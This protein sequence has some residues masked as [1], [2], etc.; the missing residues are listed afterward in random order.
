MSDTKA[1]GDCG[2]CGGT[3]KIGLITDAYDEF[4]PECKQRIP[5]QAP[6]PTCL[7]HFKAVDEAVE[8][9][10]ERCAGLDI[11]ISRDMKEAS[12]ILRK[13]ELFAA[14]WHEAAKRY[15]EAI[16]HPQGQPQGGKE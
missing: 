11:G 5:E 13:N 14:G 3:G 9:E 7:A 15:T 8:Q 1:W 12:P 4:C 2:M 16:R 10:R 6:C